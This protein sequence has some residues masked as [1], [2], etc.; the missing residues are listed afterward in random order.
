[1]TLSLGNELERRLELETNSILDTVKQMLGLDP[2]YTAFDTDVI[3]SINSAL[4]TLHQMGVGPTVCF[5]IT[6]NTETWDQ[7]IGSDTDLEGIKQ[8]IFL[9]TK[10]LFDP[11][12][13]SS[14]QEAYANQIKE[15]EWRLY[16]R[17]Q[18]LEEE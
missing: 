18:N 9:K 16:V 7:I 17:F 14:V 12:S 11:P 5:S 10:Y 13:T 2:S 4:M 1:M 3:V 6:G 15:L 8:Y